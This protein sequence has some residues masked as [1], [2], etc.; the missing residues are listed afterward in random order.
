[1]SREFWGQLYT[2]NRGSGVGAIPFDPV[3]RRQST[4]PK[5]CYNGFSGLQTKDMRTAFRILAI[6]TMGAMLAPSVRWA[7]LRGP[8]EACECLPGACTCA[9]HYHAS[10]HKSG[11]CMGMGGHCGMGAQ[12]SYFSSVL[13]TWIFVP[14][15]YA[16]SNPPATSSFGHDAAHITLLPS[17]VRVPEHPPRPT[18]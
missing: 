2:N 7:S 1:M 8:V 14:T 6:L 5:T 18:L 3:C 11:C 17:H 13:S 9:T 10:G 16:W 12:D 15:E 4:S